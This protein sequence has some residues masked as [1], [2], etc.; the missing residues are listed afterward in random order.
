MSD[1]LRPHEL[2]HTRPPC[3]SPTPGV[4]SN[5][6]PLS[7]WC[8]PTILFSVVPFSSCPQSFPATGPLQMSQ[9]FTSDGQSIGQ[10]YAYNWRR[11]WQSTPVLL[12]GKSHGQRSVVGYSL[13]GC[14]ESDT[15]DWLHFISLHMHIIT[16]KLD[17]LDFCCCCSMLYC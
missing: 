11:K 6:C 5:S 17:F 8:H 9:L 16:P 3:P 2:Q 10:L 13:W 4:Y 15:T 12:P 7:W 14:K 1:F